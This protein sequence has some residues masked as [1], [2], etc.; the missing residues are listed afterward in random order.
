MYADD[1]HLT[2]ANKDNRHLE[3]GLN[4]DLTKVT[5]WLIVNK[6]TLKQVEDGVY[7]DQI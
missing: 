2:F 3:E 7:I 6:L 4:D 5:K 1:T